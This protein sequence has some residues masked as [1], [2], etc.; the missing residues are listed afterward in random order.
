RDVLREATFQ[1]CHS[2][3]VFKSIKIGII[4]FIKNRDNLISEIF[5]YLFFLSIFSLIFSP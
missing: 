4:L 3:Y 5:F 1:G 2:I